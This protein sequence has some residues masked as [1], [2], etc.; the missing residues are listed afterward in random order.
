M[1]REFWRLIA[2]GKRTEEAAA[3]V[4]VSVPVG[5]RWFRHA[6]GMAP[7]P[8]AE[9][10]GRY[11]SFEEREE[12]A[13]LKARGL[14]VRAIAREL[15]RDP[16]TI[17]REV[18]RNAATRG[19]KLE[20]RATVAQWKAQTA[21][22]RPK[23]AKLVTNPRL[24]D[25]VQVRL[26][27]QLRRPDGTLAPGP[28]TTWKG[29]NKPHRGDRRWA[30][31]WSPEQISRRL[32]VDFPDDEDM[33]ISHEAIYQ[34]LYIQGRGALQ[35][36]LVACLR[37][38]RALRKPRE[39]ARNRPQGHVTADVVLAER[40]AEAEDRAVP[41]HW[42][43]DLMIGLNRSAIGTL[44]ERTSRYTLLVHLPRLEGYGTVPPVKNGPALGG[45]GAI[46][47]KDALSATM[48]TMPSELLRSLT[49]DRG[50]ELSAHAKF[51]IDTGIAV[52]FADPHSPWQR[53]TNENTNGLLRQ[54]FPKG[55]DL[56]R[57]PAE[58]LLA[59]QAAINS[60]PRKVLGWRTPAEVLDEQLR[61]LQQAGVASTG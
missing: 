47:M 11:L 9:P 28:A 51:K 12:I 23:P 48:T 5:S 52:Y 34:A 15:R 32:V 54:Y 18:R 35:R 31:A 59:V 55:T 8:L 25:Y 49:W 37:T 57:W 3:G 1:E 30:T 10:T 22:R 24:Q 53:G 50:K 13:L 16:G 61:S 29:L 36:E 14:G 27:G 56:S 33:R 40:P 44:V 58:D 6:G 20:Y 38:G 17:S 45:Y 39:R 43:G 4:G 19:G 26:S 21:A 7:L 42:E 46:A 41:G 60:R 2:T